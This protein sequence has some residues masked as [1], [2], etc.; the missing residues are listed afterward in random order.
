MRQD[1]IFDGKALINMGIVFENLGPDGTGK[2]VDLRIWIGI[3]QS[4]ER[5]GGP[6]GIAQTCCRHNEDMCMGRYWFSMMLVK[7]TKSC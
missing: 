6:K 1:G 7:P 2:Q 4:F 3:F 5:R